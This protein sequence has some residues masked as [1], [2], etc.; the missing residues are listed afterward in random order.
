VDRSAKRLAVPTHSSGRGTRCAIDCTDVPPA[1][2]RKVP[3]TMGADPSFGE[4]SLGLSLVIRHP[5]ALPAD[6][7]ECFACAL[8][9][10]G[11]VDRS[12]KMSCEG[13]LQH[14]RI[15]KGPHEGYSSAI[16]EADTQIARTDAPVRPMNR[17]AIDRVFPSGDVAAKY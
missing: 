5:A 13:H 9:R 11:R 1:A 3:A 8:H 7:F 10:K 14:G 16:P 6:L 17:S 4:L 2:A 12:P 15:E